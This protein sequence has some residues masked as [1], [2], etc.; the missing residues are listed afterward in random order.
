MALKEVKETTS[1]VQKFSK[2]ELEQLTT[3]Q[4]KSQNATMQFGKLYLNKIRLE[5]SENALKNYVNS[6]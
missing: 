5:E 2:E 3:L 1:E 6:I 4:S